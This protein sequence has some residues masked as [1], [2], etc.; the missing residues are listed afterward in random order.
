MLTD[1]FEAFYLQKLT[2]TPSP[3]GGSVETWADD[4]AFQAGIWIDN[5]AEA[6]IAYRTGLKTQYSIILPDG[7][8]L[9]HNDR[10]RRVSDGKTY[11]IT[12]GMSHTPAPAQLQYGRVTAEVIE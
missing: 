8:T 3:L 5:S 7:L 11:L 9:T 10:I 12:S 6:R 2:S 4:T 1:Y